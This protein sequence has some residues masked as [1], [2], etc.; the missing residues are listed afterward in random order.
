MKDIVRMFKLVTGEM[1]I[2]KI[3]STRQDGYELSYPLSVVPIPNQQNQIGFAKSMP[4]SNYSKPIILFSDSISVDSEADEKITSAY[5]QQVR[6][7]KSQESGI[8]LS[9]SIPK[10][11]LK[12]AAAKDFGELNI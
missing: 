3:K 9:N 11:L 8:I 2:T 6:Q 10:E 4:F 5:E 12:D 1:I 7:L